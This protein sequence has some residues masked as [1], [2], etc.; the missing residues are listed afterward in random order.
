M[1][2]M[3]DLMY[4]TLYHGNDHQVGCLSFMIALGLFIGCMVMD[5]LLFL[6]V[7]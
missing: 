4:M 7:P 6:V 1:L 5:I 2:Q 3:I